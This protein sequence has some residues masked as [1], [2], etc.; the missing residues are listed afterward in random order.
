[1]ENSQ[2]TSLSFFMDG[3][4]SYA[5]VLTRNPA[6]SADLVQETYV[7]A[8]RAKQGLRP[9]SNVK[10]WLFTILR[11]IWLNQLRHERTAPKII[12]LEAD[13]S[14]ADVAVSTTKD[15]HALY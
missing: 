7:R 2:D 5:M 10:G 6:A 4:Y 12:D 1:M 14:L 13:Q 15:P 11:N 8:L 9:D 3:L